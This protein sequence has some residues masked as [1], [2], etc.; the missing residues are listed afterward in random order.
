MFKSS[1]S[2]A[3]D[4]IRLTLYIATGFWALKVIVALYRNF[5]ESIAK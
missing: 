2:F 1:G 3:W 4:V 5:R